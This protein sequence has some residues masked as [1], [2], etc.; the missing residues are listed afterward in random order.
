MRW[1]RFSS[2]ITH[3]THKYGAY[4]NKKKTCT[5]KLAFITFHIIYSFNN[6]PTPQ[7]IIEISYYKSIMMAIPLIINL[8]LL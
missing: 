8:Y 1:V 6:C 5:Y 4:I 3:M 7:T 2:V